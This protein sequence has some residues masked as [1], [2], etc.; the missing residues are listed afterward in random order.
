[1]VFVYHFLHI[2]MCYT[3]IPHWL[4][5]LFLTKATELNVC[6]PGRFQCF[7]G[8]IIK[9]NYFH[10]HHVLKHYEGLSF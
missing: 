7:P 9:Y 4:F 10:C 1:M 2:F 8:Y 3:M 6:S 5:V